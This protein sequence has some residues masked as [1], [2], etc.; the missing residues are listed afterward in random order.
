MAKLKWISISTEIFN[1][2]KIDLIRAQSNG[3]AYF[4]VWIGLICLAGQNCDGIGGLYMF[5]GMP[6]TIQALSRHLKIDVDTLRSALDLF[7][8][9]EM[10]ER[11][12]GGVIEIINFQKYHPIDRLEKLEK[13][14][15]QNR[16]RQKRK[17]ERD[18]QLRITDNTLKDSKD[19]K[20]IKDIKVT[21][22]NVT[23]NVT[24]YPVDF[25]W[26]WGEYPKKKSKGAAFKAW[27]K[28]NPDDLLVS[29]IIGSVEQHK[30]TKDWQK[31]NGQFIPYPA[32]YL[33]QRMWEDEIESNDPFAGRR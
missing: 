19:I 8:G 32:S 33:N 10:I 29:T 13:Y 30:E 5:N 21:L 28:I 24:E 1:D 12:E 2:E 9:L 27:Q 6:Y 31:D 15:Q 16:D 26:F 23:N 20:D 3:S 11:T 25:L 22:R 14:E 4:E 7:E 18:K 17:R